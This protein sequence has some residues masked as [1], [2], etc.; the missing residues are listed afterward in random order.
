MFP[1]RSKDFREF[2]WTIVFFSCSALC[3]FIHRQCEPPSRNP[4]VEE[5]HESRQGNVWAMTSAVSKYFWND[6]KK[7]RRCFFFLFHWKCNKTRKKNAFNRQN[8]SKGNIF[9]FYIRC[10]IFISES[11]VLMVSV[12]R[13]SWLEFFTFGSLFCFAFGGF[14]GGSFLRVLI[15]G[16]I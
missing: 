1:K 5:N 8:H 2:D 14:P 10:L 16:F 6:S 3:S 13:W 7:F 4:P 15:G 11:D 9:L 12:R